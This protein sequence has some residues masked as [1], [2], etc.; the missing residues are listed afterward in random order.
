MLIHDTKKVAKNNLG[1]LSRGLVLATVLVLMNSGALRAEI[2]QIPLFLTTDVDPNI[3]FILDDSGSMFFEVT[4]DNLAFP[5]SSYAGFVFPRANNV[6]GPSDYAQNFIM[7]STVDANN[8][9]TARTR[10]PQFNATYYKPSVT[11][12]PW[13]RHDNTLYPDAAAQ[14]AWHNPEE[15]GPCP[16]GSINADARNLTVNNTNYNGNYWRSCN[17]VG[18]CS[19]TTNSKTFWPA[20]YYWHNSGTGW[21]W[22]DYTPVEIRSTTSSYT[23]HG[24]ETRTDAGC[25]AGTC[26]YAAEIQN[27]ANWYTYYRSRILASRA[28]IG[29]AFAEQGDNIRVGYGTIN[30]SS[31][32][33]DN[34][35]THTIV[36]GVRPFSDSDRQSFYNL[37]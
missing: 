22:T 14:C 36:Q 23:G 32:T 5:G 24:R 34:V 30:A 21:A 33:V 1:R 16:A 4:P 9:Y 11:Y 3:M 2:A 7:V 8:A 17:S 37:L 27:F 26:T 18:S 6:Y 15:T 25:V 31:S 20:T 12:A 35:S 13:T 29:Q 10:S 28:G 19:S